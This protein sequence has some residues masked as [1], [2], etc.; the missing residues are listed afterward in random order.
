MSGQ[1]IFKAVT[2]IFLIA[3]P[4]YTIFFLKD[5][6][7]VKLSLLST[8]MIFMLILRFLV[9]VVVSIQCK[10]FSEKNLKHSAL[11]SMFSEI[12]WIISLIKRPKGKNKE[13][14]P[15][16]ILPP[17]PEKKTSPRKSLNETTDQVASNCP[18][19]TTASDNN[20]DS[21]KA[22][23][24]NIPPQVTAEDKEKLSAAMQ[25][26]FAAATSGGKSETK[27]PSDSLPYGLTEDE[28]KRDP[29][30]LKF[31]GDLKN[32]ELAKY[33]ILALVQKLKEEEEYEHMLT[34][35]LGDVNG[36]LSLKEGNNN[37]YDRLEERAR[38]IEKK[39]LVLREKM[40][41][42]HPLAI[43]TSLPWGNS[44]GSEGDD[45]YGSFLE[46]SVVDEDAIKNLVNK[47]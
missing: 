3:I 4:I 8:G 29:V 38:T 43:G 21:K 35:F 41:D 36:L 2:L 6:L 22:V 9:G 13:A 1:K 5:G 40:G 37:T 34:D 42:N 11:N 39:R 20:T 19:K 30:L 28:I 7:P 47:N 26:V 46:S 10:T 27:N 23:N 14:T 33:R 44:E 25:K 18:Q 15:K 45:L 31:L 17:K 16:S 24:Q 32:I 12:F